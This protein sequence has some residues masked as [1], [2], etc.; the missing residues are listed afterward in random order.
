TERP[1]LSPDHAAASQ[2]LPEAEDLPGYH[3]L[4]RNGTYLVFR[5]LE[6]DVAG[7]WHFLDRQADG[8]VARREALAAAMVGR[9]RD[10]T[11]LVAA[12]DNPIDGID[13]ANAN[14]HFTYD[15]DPF[16][17]GCPIGAHVRRSNTRTGDYPVGVSGLFTR[18]IS[19]QRFGRRHDGDELVASSRFHL[20]LR[21]CRI[22]GPARSS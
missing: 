2:Y 8:D 22:F 16:G 15:K 19:T 1:L 10:G 6:Q 11:P 17:H 7:F 12:A 4:G 9:K 14:N 18:I 20:L 3:D 21:R 5:Q 13:P